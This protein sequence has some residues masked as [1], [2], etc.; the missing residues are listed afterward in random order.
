[1]A[2]TDL[3]KFLEALTQNQTRYAKPERYY[4]GSHDL[5]YATEKFVNAFG[6][7]FHEFALNL[8]PAVVD[9]VADKLI[10][11]GFSVESG[12]ADTAIS[13]AAWAIWQRNRMAQRSGE[14]HTEAVKTGDSYVIVWPNEAGTATIY[15]QRAA[16]VTVVYDEENP[17]RIIRAAKFWRTEDKR[18]RLNLYYPDRIEKF[19]SKKRLELTLPGEN[20]FTALDDGEIKNPFGVVPVFH[21]SNSGAMGALGTS[22]LKNAIPVQDGLNKSILDMLVA[23]EF[24]AYRQRWA[25]GIEIEYDEAGNPKQ[26]YRA[27]VERLWISESPEAKFGDF[28]ATDARQFTEITEN[29]VTNLARVTGIPLHYFTQ[30]GGNAP[31]GEALRKSES[32]FIAKIKRRQETFGNVWEDAIRLALLIDKQATDARLITEWEDP[33]PASDAELLQ[34]LLLKKELG[35]TDEQLLTE[36]GYGAAEVA[37]ALAEKERKAEA[38]ATQFNRGETGGI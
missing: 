36:A 30:S 17:G 31:S 16:N 10:V 26:P 12:G 29:F 15:P 11:T 33:A 19:I 27:G 37:A 28:A 38:F 3:G 8:C 7:L 4:D 24:A 13:D 34:N 5:A 20:E 9:A 14:V 32:R 6:Q 35:A 21:F 1:M 25:A 2:T 22:E 18:V 23:M